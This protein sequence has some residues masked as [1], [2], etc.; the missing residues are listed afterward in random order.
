M[1]DRRERLGGVPECRMGGHVQRG[2]FVEVYGI[3]VLDAI[4]KR[5]DVR[6]IHDATLIRPSGSQFPAAGIKSCKVGHRLSHDCALNTAMQFEHGP[7]PPS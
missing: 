3:G 7:I 1:I 2:R 6:I 4:V 5:L